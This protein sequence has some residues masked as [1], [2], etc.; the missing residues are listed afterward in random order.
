MT[1]E[2]IMLSVLIILQ[3]T[4]LAFWFK[5]FKRDTKVIESRYRVFSEHVRDTYQNIDKYNNLS[6][7][8]EEMRSFIAKTEMSNKKISQEIQDNLDQLSVKLRS[9]YN[10]S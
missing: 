4:N 2:E 10:N 8:V 9:L 3:I 6:A 5:R 7:A 1:N